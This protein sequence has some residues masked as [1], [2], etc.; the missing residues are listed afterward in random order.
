MKK[1]A[2][3]VGL[4][5]VIGLLG[6]WIVITSGVLTDG[7]GNGASGGSGGEPSPHRTGDAEESPFSKFIDRAETGLLE[8]DN[9]RQ[10]G[11]RS[12]YRAIS[13][14]KDG[15]RTFVP[16]GVPADIPVVELRFFETSGDGKQEPVDVEGAL[17]NR[18]QNGKIM[19]SE[20]HELD[21]N[22][23]VDGHS[24]RLGVSPQGSGQP[25]T[26]RFSHRYRIQYM[27]PEKRD[28]MGDT[29]YGYPWYENVFA[30]PDEI[31]RGKIAVINLFTRY[32][33]PTLTRKSKKLSKPPKQIRGTIKADLRAHGQHLEVGYFLSGR[34][35]K[36]FPRFDGSFSLQA[37]KLGGMLRVTERKRQAVGWM[38]VR[39]VQKRR[40]RL[41]EDA[42]VVIE[43]DDLVEFKLRIRPENITKDLA[44]ISVKLKRDDPVP[45][46]WI[47]FDAKD[48]H[49]HKE[50]QQTHTLDMSFIPGQH[51]VLALYWPRKT[52]WDKRK[53]KV[54]GQLQVEK[55]DAS[56]TLEVEPLEE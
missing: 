9:P 15:V 53:V 21:T 11:H 12:L 51:W 20:D 32:P 5:L 45:M 10:A 29:G 17:F 46:A 8:N 34:S 40:L 24:L 3:A 13:E 36:T 22:L 47:N 42:D 6:G 48:R 19:E 30:V 1:L 14:V 26:L 44:R 23:E 54:L 4:L 28:E 33:L 35:D 39:S 27:V 43:P 41:P 52:A 49:L 25:E 16:P 56:K 18:W 38:C 7:S 50:L 2:V 55:S 31:P 37:E